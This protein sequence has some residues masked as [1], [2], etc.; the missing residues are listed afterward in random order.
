MVN[1]KNFFETGCIASMKLYLPRS[2]QGSSFMATFKRSVI[3]FANGI[4]NSFRDRIIVLQQF[5]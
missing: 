3:P 1:R 2:V 4:P 5:Y